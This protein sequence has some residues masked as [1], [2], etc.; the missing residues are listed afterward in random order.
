MSLKSIRDSY[1]KLLNTFN[2]AGIKLNE[3]QKTDLDG[4]VLAIESTMSKQRESAIKKTKKVV[5]EKLEGE[6]KSLFESILAKVRENNI[7]ASKIQ[8][9]N[10]KMVESKKIAENVDKYLE[11]Y[12]E[13]VLPK[14]TIIDY[15]RMQKLE[16]LHESLKDMLVVDDKAI[17]DKAKALDESMKTE[18]SKCETEVAKMQVKLNESEKKINSLKKKLDS[19]KA[20]E[21][22]ESK[23]RDLPDFEAHA[24]KKRLAESTAEEIEETFDQTLESV[25]KDAKKLA[26]ENDAE[27]EKTLDEEIEKIV[28]E[29]DKEDISETEKVDEDDI[30]KKTPHNGDA[31]HNG[32]IKESEEED[33]EIDEEEEEFETTETVKEDEDGNIELD[34]SDIIDPELMKLWCNQSIEVR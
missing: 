15:D 33:D 30:L 6:F 9:M 16:R 5:T 17:A 20:V 7:L 11:L 1:A 29:E 4:F 12:V 26:E 31:S 23:T 34:E 10:T 28:G 8:D 14:K 21:L 27:E 22:L 25:K 3:N 32:H 19:L 18:K 2:R 24:I 13:S